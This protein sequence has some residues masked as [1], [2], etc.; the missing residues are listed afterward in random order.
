MST[1]NQRAVLRAFCRQ[2]H[3]QG[4]FWAA[5]LGRL[6]YATVG[7]ALILQIQGATGSYSAAGTAA[8]AYSLTAALLAPLR[9]LLVD[10]WGRRRALPPMALTTALL[11]TCI[12]VYG[13]RLGAA[14]L[15]LI[16]LSGLVGCGLPPLGPVTRGVWA[17]AAG[18]PAELRAAYS[19]DTVAEEGLFTAGPLLV[20]VVVAAADARA[21]L[22]L[23]AVLM[24]VGTAAMVRSPLMRAAVAA[25]PTEAE[26]R[27]ASS[28]LRRPAFL[29][30][31]VV[32]L[33]IGVGLGGVELAAIA[34]SRADGPA[35]TGA[36]LA[37][38]NLG[39]AAGG[40]AYGARSWRSEGSTHLLVLC[41]LLA[42]GITG[43]AVLSGSAALPVFGA[44]SFLVGLCISPLLIAAYTS[45]DGLSDLSTRTQASTLV[46]TVNNLGV[47]IG[48]A[49]TGILLDSGG[50]ERAFLVGA[51]AMAGT[52]AVAAVHRSRVTSL[53]PT[54]S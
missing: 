35:G 40:I 13:Q 33:G 25:P 23:T 38:L 30:L 7:F 52:T 4:F 28:L 46:G 44:A 49:V 29:S 1:S 47:S 10:R 3:V 31:L 17:D 14:P 39:S 51:L 43:L 6:S 8:V 21:A 15:C 27:R 9:A 45:A 50:P 18:S 24:L 41:A 2:P 20:G 54:S 16:A 37:A 32:L 5:M 12:A 36:V 53:L 19:L 22:L 11:L 26:E 42:I 34:V 48:T